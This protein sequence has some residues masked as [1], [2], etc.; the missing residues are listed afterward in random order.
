MLN[1]RQQ[2]ARAVRLRHIVITSR[3]PRCLFFPIQRV[4]GDGDDRNRSHRGI[5]LDLARD[6]VAVHDRQLDTHEDEIGSLFFHY[7]KRLLTVLGFRDFVIG[8]SDCLVLA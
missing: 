5:G 1:F 6:L 3:R 4:G 8:A 7:R 2:L